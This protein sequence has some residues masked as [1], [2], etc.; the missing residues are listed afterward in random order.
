MRFDTTNNFPLSAADIA[1]D[2]WFLRFCIGLIFVYLGVG[3]FIGL[4][5]PTGTPSAL[6]ADAKCWKGAS[7]DDDGRSV[8]LQ[9]AR[10][11]LK[12]PSASRLDAIAHQACSP[13][14]ARDL[15]ASWITAFKVGCRAGYKSP[16]LP[17]PL[18]V[19]SL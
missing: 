10:R 6:L 12:S 13:T 15:Q 17:A 14:T 9:H 19:A 18:S 11:G 2:R 16:G 4:S 1:T 7:G 3:L 5:R 8:C